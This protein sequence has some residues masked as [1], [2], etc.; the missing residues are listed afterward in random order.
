[1][2]SVVI[3]MLCLLT[4]VPALRLSIIYGAYELNKTQI[5]EA[6]CINI[7]KPALMCSGKCYVNDIIAQS[8]ASDS[9]QAPLPA[10]E[11]LR[12]IVPFFPECSCLPPLVV[13][14][15][16][17]SLPVIAD[18]ALRQRLYTAAVFKPPRA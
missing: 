2:K 17:Q 15:Q 5:T 10:V 11:D 7:D 8:A 1:M 14:Q 13:A 4:V 18:E 6:Y 9:D 12:P 3:S 16:G